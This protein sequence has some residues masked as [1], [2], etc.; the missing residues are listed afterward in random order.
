MNANMI[1]IVITLLCA[2]PDW[3]AE[4]MDVEGAFLQGKFKDG[5]RLYVEIPD[6]M[7]KYYG[8]PSDT[9]LLMNIP[10]YGTK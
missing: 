7:A 8:D 10:M 2:N 3:V 5:E 9:V 1:R 4:V 6:G